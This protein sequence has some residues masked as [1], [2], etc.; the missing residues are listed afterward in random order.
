MHGPDAAHHRADIQGLR[1]I[2]VLL[3]VV[4][5]TGIGLPGGFVGVDVFF[6]V[7]GYVIAR[8]L[9]R[10]L[11]ATGTV[12]LREFYARRA[13]RLLPALALVSVVTLGLSLLVLSPFGEQ[14]DAIS[15]ARATALFGA[16]LYFLRQQAYFEL[17]D[18]P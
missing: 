12:S 13:R 11:D 7:S 15:A 18:N 10:E 8:L 17:A 16:N 6:V 9:L 5:H 1:G 4:Y 14:Q 3:V 2:A